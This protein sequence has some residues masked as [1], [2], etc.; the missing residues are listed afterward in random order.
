MTAELARVFVQVIVPVLLVGGFGYLVGRSRAIDLEPITA[1]AVSVLVPGVVF[2]SLA[3]A[4]LP[5]AAA[6]RASARRPAARWWR[7]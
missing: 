3:R 6:P 1:L 4:A 2:D 5:R 7:P